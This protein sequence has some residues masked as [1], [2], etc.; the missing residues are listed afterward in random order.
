[1]PD[2]IEGLALSGLCSIGGQVGLFDRMS[3]TDLFLWGEHHSESHA[4]HPLQLL[5]CRVSA[6]NRIWLME[7]HLLRVGLT[8]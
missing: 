7:E 6:T 5:Q 2:G 8:A 3:T 4:R 1:M